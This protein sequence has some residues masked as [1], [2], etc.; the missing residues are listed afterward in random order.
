[1]SNEP[2]RRG[3]SPKPMSV[4]GVWKGL[5][6]FTRSC[7]MSWFHAV[8]FQ[9]PDISFPRWS[10]T[11]SHQTGNQTVATVCVCRCNLASS[12]GLGGLILRSFLTF[13]R[14]LQLS[15]ENIIGSF[16]RCSHTVP[17]PP[18]R[19]FRWTKT[20]TRHTCPVFRAPKLQ[21]FI[22]S[23]CQRCPDAAFFQVFF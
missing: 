2:V 10:R 22:G 9:L 21:I 13:W 23:S 19:S 16:K 14:L 17:N 15:V 7:C 12:R 8:Q 18:E 20:W 1:M 3:L 5:A 6:E 4:A 11:G